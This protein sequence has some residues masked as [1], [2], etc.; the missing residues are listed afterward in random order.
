MVH[1]LFSLNNPPPNTGELVSEKWTGQLPAFAT[2][3][4][5][6]RVARVAC[7]AGFSGGFS[8]MAAL[9]HSRRMAPGR[10]EAVT[11]AELIGIPDTFRWDHTARR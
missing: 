7:S 9:W 5:F 10:F 8:R 3:V 1:S 4:R 2:T 11:I 6:G